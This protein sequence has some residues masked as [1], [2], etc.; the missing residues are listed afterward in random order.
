MG[1]Q[2]A[3]LTTSEAHR[4]VVQVVCNR[5]GKIMNAIIARFV[6]IVLAA[7]LLSGVVSAQQTASQSD[8]NNSSAR[9]FL[10]SSKRPQVQLNSGV[11]RATGAVRGFAGDAPTFEFTMYPAN[12]ASDDGKRRADATVIS[13]RSQNVEKLSDE[14]YRA[15]GVL[16]VTYVESKETYDPNEAHANPTFGPSIT[17]SV[18]GD[19]TFDFHPVRHA[20]TDSGSA[21]TDWRA[22]TL[23]VGRKFPELLLAI[24][25]TPWPDYT[26]AEDCSMPLTVAEDFSGPSCTGGTSVAASVRTDTQC[27]MPPTMGEDFS[28]RVCH[29]SP[30]Q[31]P[32]AREIRQMAE[33]DDT[34]PNTLVADQVQIVVYLRVTDVHPAVAGSD[35]N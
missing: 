12:Q 5:K 19:A 20:N 4:R 24:S 8:I 23:I 28:G 6:W 30:L 31:T 1:E 21:Y 29:G 18:Q 10:S 14:D 26:A 35:G 17:Y 16:T 34:P 9:I 22:S 7:V 11:A 25:T 27:G 15:S 2:I 32:T 33:D 3:I 13:F